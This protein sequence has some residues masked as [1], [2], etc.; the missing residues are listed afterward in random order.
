M[1]CDKH[2][3]N[4]EPEW[5][6]HWAKFKFAM[7]DRFKTGHEEYGDNPGTFSRPGE[8]LICEI[9]EEAEDIIGW[10]FALRV[11]LLK[12]LEDVRGLYPEARANELLQSARKQ[13][14]NL[15]QE[16][17]RLRAEIQRL[18]GMWEREKEDRVITSKD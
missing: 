6:A 16:N 13:S 5:E 1:A 3:P 10:G 4:C 15:I 11:R 8:E 7:E 2:G 18:G 9:I 17:V 14:D 12:M